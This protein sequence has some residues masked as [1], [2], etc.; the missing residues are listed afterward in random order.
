[1]PAELDE[2]R[3]R[4]IALGYLAELRRLLE[5]ADLDALSRIVQRLRVARDAGATRTGTSTPTT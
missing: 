5:E 4:Q 3:I 2:T 1:M